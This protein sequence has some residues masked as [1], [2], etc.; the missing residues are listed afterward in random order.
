KAKI[1]IYRRDPQ[2]VKQELIDLARNSAAADFQ[3]DTI[4]PIT[5]IEDGQQTFAVYKCTR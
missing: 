3:G 4:V 2:K 1:G 5:E